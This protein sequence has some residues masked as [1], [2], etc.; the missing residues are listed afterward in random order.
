MFIKAIWETFDSQRNF[1]WSAMQEETEKIG[2]LKSLD[3]VPARNVL[4]F[5]V[6]NVEDI[7]FTETNKF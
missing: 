5:V 2:Y 6:A 4:V 1:D 3:S 7:L